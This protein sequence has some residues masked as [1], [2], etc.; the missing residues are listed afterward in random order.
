MLLNVQRLKKCGL[1]FNACLLLMPRPKQCRFIISLPRWKRVIPPL[2]II[3]NVLRVS[4]I[5]LQQSVN[6]LTLLKLSHSFWL[7]STST[8]TPLWP[9]SLPVLNR[10]LA[11]EE[12]Y[13][14][15]LAHEQ[16]LQHHISSMDAVNVT[17]AGANFV[18]WGRSQ[19]G[20]RSSSFNNGCGSSRLFYNRPYPHSPNYRGR[21][22]GRSSNTSSFQRLIC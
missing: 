12:I 16:R 19:R 15:L 1:L 2:Q 11:I 8:M 7:A 14:H 18:S 10:P 13:G 9:L 6:P 4:R 17:L 5:L 3:F 20:G 21:G 22:Y